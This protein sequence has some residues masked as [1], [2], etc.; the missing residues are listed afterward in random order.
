MQAPESSFYL[1]RAGETPVGS[2][3]LQIDLDPTRVL[4]KFSAFSIDPAWEKKG[5]GRFMS[6]AIEA[7]VCEVARTKGL[8]AATLEM[9]VIN[10]RKDL[11]TFWGKLGFSIDRDLPADPE[12]SRISL[13]G[14]DVH[15]VL[16]KKQ[17]L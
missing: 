13:D 10:V 11:F 3:Y 14:L 5:V 12:L 17:L 16:M 7:R 9:G 2:V 4:G 1:A 8:G 6:A 15:C